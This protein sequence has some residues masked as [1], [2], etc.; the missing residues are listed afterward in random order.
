MSPP[1]PKSPRDLKSDGSLKTKKKKLWVFLYPRTVFFREAQAET[2]DKRSWFDWAVPSLAFFFFPRLARSLALSLARSQHGNLPEQSWRSSS[3]CQP[4]WILVFQKDALCESIN[5]F[6]NR[7]LWVSNQILAPTAA[8][9]CQTGFIDFMVPYLLQWMQ[10][11]CSRIVEH[12]KPFPVL[13]GRRNL[14][15]KNVRM[16][17]MNNLQ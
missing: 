15:A 9:C 6:P 4:V 2:A 16:R 8:C 12:W 13:A 10:R 1:L 14:L 17:H 7:K 11:L 5:R 3:L